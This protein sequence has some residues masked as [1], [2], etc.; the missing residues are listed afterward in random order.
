[1]NKTASLE[2][3]LEAL[4]TFK[5]LGYYVQAGHI[6][7]DYG[8]TIEEL[9]ENL[10]AMKKYSW[11]I[12]KG[13]FTEMY[14]AEGTA[15]TAWLVRKGMSEGV[16]NGLGNRPYRFLNA[17]IEPIYRALKKWHMQHQ[18][19]YDMAIDILSAPKAVTVSQ[20][21]SFHEIAC[22]LRE[23]DLAFLEKVL[24]LA[25]S[26]ATKQELNEFVKQEIGAS[27]EHY[28]A[29]G[30]HVQQLYARSGMTYDGEKNPF[31]VE[32]S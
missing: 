16:D 9:W 4:D 6:L 3:N 27:I 1:M 13:V 12:S 29:I 28:K 7:F 10:A 11:T 24:W 15:Y 25:D 20:M 23:L 5:S 19:V 14:A 30:M 17:H 22:K 31:I 2:Q 18:Q 26:R 8:T 21:S 32:H